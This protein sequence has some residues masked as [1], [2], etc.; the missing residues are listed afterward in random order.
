LAAVLIYL[1]GQGIVFKYAAASFLHE[2]GHWAAIYALGGGV[3]LLRLSFTGAEMQLDP[4]RPLSYGRELIAALC[5]PVVNL[6]A[7]YCFGVCKQY[8]FAGINLSLGLLN[9][10]PIYPL[11]GGRILSCGLCIKWPDRADNVVK[12]ISAICTGLLC[13]IGLAAWNQWGNITLLVISIWLI[14]GIIK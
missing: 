7:A 9:L 13:G 10:L 11:D 3:R 12:T 8:L 1:D 5:G 14:F 2:A 6:A 4:Y